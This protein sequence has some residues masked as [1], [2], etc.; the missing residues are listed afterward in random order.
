MGPHKIVHDAG[1]AALTA[2]TARDFDGAIVEVERMN[3]ASLDVVR[4]LG[5]LSI[6]LDTASDDSDLREFDRL[7]GCRQVCNARLDSDNRSQITLS[8]PPCRSVKKGR[9]LF[10]S[11]SLLQR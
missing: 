6:S 8:L 7:K 9:Q 1:K 5:E 10:V 4:L 11:Q 2:F 3:D